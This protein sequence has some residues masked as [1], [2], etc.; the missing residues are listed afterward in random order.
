MR[1]DTDERRGD[2]AGPFDLPDSYETESADSDGP[3]GPSLVDEI[4]VLFEDGRNYA[5][6]EI[7]FQKSRL[8]FVADRAKG[9]I[10]FGIGAVILLHITLIALAVGVVIALIP[11]VGAWGA[12]AIVA[13]ILLAG[14]IYLALMLKARL[15]AIAAAFAEEGK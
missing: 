7:A 8:A 4:G 15:E 13:G 2:Y 14:S 12:T 9:A 1:D 10:A 3:E 11:L 5:E 6:A